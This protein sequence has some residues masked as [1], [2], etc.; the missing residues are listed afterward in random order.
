MPTFIFYRDNERVRTP[1][2]CLQADAPQI[3][4]LIGA[5][6]KTLAETLEFFTHNPGASLI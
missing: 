4:E 2:C 3:A 6:A 1:K 5:T